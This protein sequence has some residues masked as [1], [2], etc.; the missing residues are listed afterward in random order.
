MGS[1]EDGLGCKQKSLLSLG[2]GELSSTYCLWGPVLGLTDELKGF[3]SSGFS[4][5]TWSP[6]FTAGAHARKCSV[7]FVTRLR[8]LSSW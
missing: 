3:Q 1:W 6:P 7:A 5:A 8:L 4:C 2:A